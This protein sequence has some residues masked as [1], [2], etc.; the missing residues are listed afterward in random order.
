MVTAEFPGDRRS[1]T[2]ATETTSAA[3]KSSRSPAIERWLQPNGWLLLGMWLFAALHFYNVWPTLGVVFRDTDDLMRLAEVRDFLAGQGWFDLHQY[4]LDPPAD[5]PMH[6]SRFVDLPIA[7]LIRLFSLG[8]DPANAT[9]A[10]MFVWPAIPF[11]PVLWA[12]RT[13][14]VRFGGGWAAFPAVYLM[15]TLGLVV[16]QFVP[17]RIDHHNVQIMLTMVLLAV[18]AGPAGRKRGALVG[19]LGAV[20]MAIGMETLPFLILAV[21][22]LAVAW[23]VDGDEAGETKAFGLTL[24]AATLAVAGATLPPSEWGRGACDALSLNYV[25]LAVVGGI[26][27][28]GA[29]AW[30]PSGRGGRGGLLAGV[31]IAAIAA[32]AW[33]EPACLKGPFGQILPEVRSAWLDGVNEVQPWQKVFA[34]EHL[35]A[36]LALV[37]PVLG[38]L[39]FGWL[40]R[41][42]EGRRTLGFWVLGAALATALAIGLM[43]IRT[44]VYANTLAVPLVAAAIGVAGRRA[45]FGGRSISVAVLGGSILANCMVLQLA[46][47]QVAPASWRSEAALSDAAQ[48]LSSPVANQNAETTAAAAA[49]FGSACY[50]TT[51][52]EGLAALPTG[53]VV[54]DINL[55]PSILVATHH[56]VVAAPYHRMQRGIL[57]AH[58]MLHRAPAEALPLLAARGVDYLVFCSSD[59]S[60]ATAGSLLQRLEKGEAVVGLE[61]I[62]GKGVVRVYRVHRGP[63]LTAR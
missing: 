60:K 63:V 9:R 45:E 22:G 28:A 58:H 53:L 3:A 26:G 39:A 41:E 51:S 10:A 25:G 57:D 15:A 18:L 52:F 30:A 7:L 5:V 8:L 47:E 54:A 48:G 23:L 2:L 40:A 62:P 42:S 17:G 49:A 36:I 55:G 33:P 38:L 19:L 27:L 4:R 21:V 16:A 50:T 11:L 43:Q 61:E 37:T 56:S 29:A 14:G 1:M 20:M 12:S 59:R 24:A 32:F 46:L 34:E 6:W 44:M 35:G 13:L 31:A